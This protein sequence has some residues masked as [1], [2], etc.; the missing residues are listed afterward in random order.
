LQ[1]PPTGFSAAKEQR[2]KELLDRYMADE[3]TPEQYHAERAKILR[4]P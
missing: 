1:G 4:E 3:V 2:L